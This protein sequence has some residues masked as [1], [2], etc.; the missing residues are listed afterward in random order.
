MMG[1]KVVSPSFIIFGTGF[2]LGLYGLFVI[3]T[4]IGGLKI[5]VFRTLGQNPLAAYCI[6]QMVEHSVSPMVPEDSPLWW[7]MVGLGVF[8]GMTYFAVRYLEKHNIY[9]RL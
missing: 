6:H 4:D 9:L 1:K 2:A 8:F 7:C 3:A 5:G